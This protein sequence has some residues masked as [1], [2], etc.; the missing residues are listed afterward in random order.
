ML[1]VQIIETEKLKDLPLSK[2]Y[3][4]SASIRLDDVMESLKK[5]ICL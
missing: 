1:W 4:Q 5:W 2:R 3:H